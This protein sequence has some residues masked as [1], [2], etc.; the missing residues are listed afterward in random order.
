MLLSLLQPL[1]ESPQTSAISYHYFLRYKQKTEGRSQAVKSADSVR[2]DVSFAMH[3]S[4]SLSEHLRVVVRIVFVRLCTEGKPSNEAHNHPCSTE[5]TSNG[6]YSY[7][8]WLFLGNFCYHLNDLNGK[9]D[10]SCPAAEVQKKGNH[11]TQSKESSGDQHAGHSITHLWAH[12]H[13]CNS[14]NH[15]ETWHQEE[16]NVYNGS[17]TSP[18]HHHPKKGSNQATHTADH[19][20]EV[21]SDCIT[22]DILRA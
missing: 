20:W 14:T 12:N 5:D 10:E 22:V 21:C 17:G 9:W 4:I 15:A 11:T 18:C 13:Y 6:W 2:R 1:S 16:R 3:W 8:T 19:A 7:H